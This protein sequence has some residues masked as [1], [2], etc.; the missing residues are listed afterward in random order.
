MQLV[1]IKHQIAIKKLF[2]NR[3]GKFEMQWWHEKPMPLFKFK[4]AQLNR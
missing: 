2:F 1:R 3:S 4:N